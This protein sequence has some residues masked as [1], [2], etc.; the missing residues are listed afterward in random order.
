M[1]KVLVAALG[2]LALA[3]CVH[4][5]GSYRHAGSGYGSYGYGYNTGY[6]A[7]FRQR[8]AYSAHRSDWERRATWRARQERRDRRRDRW[9][10]GD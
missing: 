1:R 8:P 4:N 3:G 5:D 2:V 6:S 10:Y 7:G 9:A